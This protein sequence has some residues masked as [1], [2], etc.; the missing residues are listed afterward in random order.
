[1]W[2][3]AEGQYEGYDPDTY[4]HCGEQVVEA[5]TL[6][7]LKEKLEQYIVL[8]DSELFDGHLIYQCEGEHHYNTP[9]EEQIPFQEIFTVALYEV[10]SNNINPACLLGE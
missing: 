3:N 8:K 4:Q 6:E 9:K 1:M 10:E 7:D 2:L 5:K